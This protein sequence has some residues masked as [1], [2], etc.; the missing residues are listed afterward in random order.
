MVR[1]LV[2]T[3]LNVGKEKL[4]IKQFCYIVEVKDRFHVGPS[5]PAKGLFKKNMLSKSNRLY[6]L[7]NFI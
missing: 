1:T 5:A 7:L 3:L 4:N 6:T 2:G